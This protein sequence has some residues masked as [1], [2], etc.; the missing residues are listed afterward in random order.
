[1][2]PALL[3]LNVCLKWFSAPNLLVLEEDIGSDPVLVTFLA[4][5]LDPTKAGCRSSS[6]SSKH[7]QTNL[8]TLQREFN[9]P[10][11]SISL[12]IPWFKGFREVTETYLI[13]SE[14]P[15]RRDPPT[16]FPH[17]ADSYSSLCKQSL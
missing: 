3:R 2:Q 16:P 6:R 5:S 8:P 11:H 17:L 15:L 1:M 14:N 13:H 9:K 7:Q 4:R 12:A 10:L